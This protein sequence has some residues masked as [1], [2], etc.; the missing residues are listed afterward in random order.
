MKRKNL[1]ISIVVMFSLILI[2]ATITNLYGIDTKLAFFLV[3][4]I[5]GAYMASLLPKNK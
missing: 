4:G 1:L 5:G 2:L 3:I